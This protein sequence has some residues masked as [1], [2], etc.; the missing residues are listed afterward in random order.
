MSDV[1]DA[2]GTNR[3]TVS[4]WV[5]RYHTEGVEGLERR[6]TSGRPRKL[7]EL[8]EEELLAIVLQ[9][10]SHFGYETDLWTVGRLHSVIEDQC[11]V[12][13][14]KDTVWR[15]LREAGFNLSETRATVLRT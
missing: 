5:K 3:S 12:T 10:A 9:P 11:L 15:R 6:A 4:R 8:T 13:V 14:S 1:A 7:E 2:Y